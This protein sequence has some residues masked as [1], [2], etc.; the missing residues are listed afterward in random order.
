MSNLPIPDFILSLLENNSAEQWITALITAACVVLILL[1][2]RVLVVR[3]FARFA[4][5]TRNQLDDL[6]VEAL[7]NTRLLFVLLGSGPGPRP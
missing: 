1:V 6:L 4:E 2:V 5:K 7:K 3:R